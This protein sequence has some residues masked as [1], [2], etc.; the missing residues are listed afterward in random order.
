MK[1]DDLPSSGERRYLFREHTVK[2]SKWGNLLSLSKEILNDAR[3]PSKNGNTALRHGGDDDDDG[4][5]SGG[6]GG[7]GGNDCNAIVVCYP[8]ELPN[9]VLTFGVRGGG[10]DF[11][12]WPLDHAR[13]A[14]AKLLSGSRVYC[15]RALP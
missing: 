9:R 7:G 8:T 1:S 14:P 4:G 11:P 2:K 10:V 12:T 3:F 5:G 15:G 6:G 13:S